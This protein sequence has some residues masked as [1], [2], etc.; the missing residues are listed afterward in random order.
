MPDTP[1]SPTRAADRAGTADQGFAQEVVTCLPYLRRYARA[2]TGSQASGDRY[3]A[4]T[5]EAILADRGLLDWQIGAKVSLFRAFQSVWSSSGSKL[6]D[7]AGAAPA[8][9]E[10]RAQARM[11]NLTPQSREA[12]LLRVIEE[13]RSEEVAQIMRI[14]PPEADALVQTAMREMESEVPGKVLI[15]EDEPLIAID[16]RN[17]V[18]DMGHSV[19]GI[20]PTRRDAIRL[21]EGPRPD[22]ILADIQLADNSSGIDAVNDLLTALGDVPVVFITAFPDRLLTGQRPE[23]AFLI[24]KPFRPEQV[25]SAVSQAIFFSSTETITETD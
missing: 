25:R 18:Q 7:P 21:G 14:T 8:G 12:L 23:P 4:A 2:L 17:I 19:T 24:T 15:I 13:F 9:A 3:A 5:M 16:I 1:T 6:G 11:A 22:L 10:A 20:A